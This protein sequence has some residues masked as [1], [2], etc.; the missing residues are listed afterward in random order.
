MIPE[1][2]KEVFVGL[3]WDTTCDIDSSLLLL[4]E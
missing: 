1:S 2:M 4:D 3:G